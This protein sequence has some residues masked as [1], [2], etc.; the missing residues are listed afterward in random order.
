MLTD[1]KKNNNVTKI[2]KTMPKSIIEYNT[3]SRQLAIRNK[4]VGKSLKY[5]D[6]R[7]KPIDEKKVVLSDEDYAF[8]QGEI[9]KLSLKKLAEL[10]PPSIKHKQDA[11]VA[12]TLIVTRNDKTVR[13][14][15]F[16]HG[17][18]PTEIKALIAKI[19]ELR[20]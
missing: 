14:A 10:E 18:P 16:D 20:N 17:N 19:M 1:N 7:P 13:V 15:T 12:A 9:S 5:L 3:Y 8:I 2:V 6:L 11:A 4:L